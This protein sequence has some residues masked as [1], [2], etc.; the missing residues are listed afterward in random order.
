[1]FGE[2]IRSEILCYTTHTKTIKGPLLMYSI[3][4]GTNFQEN[5]RKK[6]CFSRL[7]CCLEVCD[8]ALIVDV[9]LQSAL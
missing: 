3:K 4:Q 7:E 9:P 5:V 1:M 6:A 8:G 2:G